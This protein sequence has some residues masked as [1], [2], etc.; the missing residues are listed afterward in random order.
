M[1]GKEFYMGVG[2]ENC[3][4]AQTDR[5]GTRLLDVFLQMQHYERWKD[6][7]QLAKDLGVNA[8]RYSV[9]WYKSNPSPGD[10]DWDWI[11]GPLDWLVENGI[12]PIIDLIH[13]G[14]PTW[15]DN[16]ILNSQFPERFAEY[17]H[18]FARRF[19]GIVDHYTPMNEPQAS[20]RKSGLSA[21]WPPY[22]SGVDGWC[23]LCLALAKAM[24][25][26]S[27]ALRDTSGNC[28]LISAECNSRIA[29]QTLA[30]A[31]GLPDLDLGSTLP[32]RLFP[33][34]LSYGMILPDD[35][36]V[37]ALGGMG[38]A[39]DDF[40]WFL[41]HA[42]PPDILGYNYYPA[43]TPGIATLVE[44][45]EQLLR[46]L[47]EVHAATGLPVYVAETSAGLND[48]EKTEWV[49]A[50]G[51]LC[52]QARGQELP[53]RGINWWPLFETILWDYRD[54]GKSVEECIVPRGWNNGLYVTNKE[55]G[56][57]LE[58]VATGAVAEFRTL[59]AD[60]L[61]KAE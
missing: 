60:V 52:R 9:P 48:E 40:Q 21:V 57:S 26:A 61:G 47:T 11:A 28:C 35:P 54:N 39:D 59:C 13:Y 2:I 27:R 18:Q 25:L 5:P 41:E 32:H 44:A 6:D 43:L 20:A 51:E 58:R 38:Y 22:L 36:L 55:R 16:G 3:W 4:M 53:L 56:A 19:D 34:S 8:I 17:A 31:A 29:Y 49:R 30:T 37:Q 14:T 10:Y 7:L 24:A 33:A 42:E 23:T 15:M 12:T 45:R 1:S 50:L 46:D